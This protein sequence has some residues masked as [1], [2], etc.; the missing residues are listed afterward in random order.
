[1]PL[2]LLCGGGLL[3]RGLLDTIGRGGYTRRRRRSE[4]RFSGSSSPMA[5]S[6]FRPPFVIPKRPRCCGLLKWCT[7]PLNL[8][9]LPTIWCSAFTFLCCM[10]SSACL[11]KIASAFQV[12]TLLLLFFWA[13]DCLHGPLQSYAE[14]A[15]FLIHSSPALAFYYVLAL[16][17]TPVR[18]TVLRLYFAKLVLGRTPTSSPLRSRVGHFLLLCGPVFSS[19][20]FCFSEFQFCFPFGNFTR[21]HSITRWFPTLFIRASSI[22]PLGAEV[23]PTGGPMQA[24][25]TGGSM[26]GT[27]LSSDTS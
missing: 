21:F 9:L 4:T 1:M 19:T 15:Y 25:P 8:A 16:G 11:C 14:P 5:P 12:G 6:S 2:R 22:N 26:Q 24:H 27:R 10:I 17:R 7:H 23:L 3:A 20:F 18:Y 13:G